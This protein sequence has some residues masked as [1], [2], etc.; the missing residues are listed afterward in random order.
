M[1]SLN[2]VSL[3]GNLGADPETRYMPD[4][5]Q[6]AICNLATTDV[7]KDKETGEKKEKTEWH[8]VIFFNGLAK[9]AGEYLKKGS[10]IYIEGK[11]RTRKWTDKRDGI[12]RYTTEVVAGE[13]QMLG[14]RD[15]KEETQFSSSDS[16]PLMSDE[17]DA[18]D[19]PF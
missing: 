13:M 11:L 2:K 1:A 7:W 4:G 12:E 15:Y 8:R 19:V 18:S 9:I 10:Q 6:T 17:A 16:T 14:K 5:T 3:I